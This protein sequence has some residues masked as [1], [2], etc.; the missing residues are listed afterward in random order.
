VETRKSTKSCVEER[1]HNGGIANL[2]AGAGDQGKFVGTLFSNAF[3]G[4]RQFTLD[5]QL[6]NNSSEGDHYQKLIY[7]DYN[8]KWT[9][10][11][12]SHAG[13]SISK[14]DL[15]T[16]TSMTQDNNFINAKEHQEQSSQN[17]ILIRLIP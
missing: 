3:K 14:E 10:K 4:D 1:K 15:S 13:I 16:L 5:G 7:L 9:P 12:T 17:K 6:S 8:D 2:E 11:W